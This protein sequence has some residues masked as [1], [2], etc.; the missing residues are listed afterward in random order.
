MLQ[1]AQYTTLEDHEILM[2]TDTMSEMG[3]QHAYQQAL[4]VLA[5]RLRGELVLPGDPD[6]EP[7]RG[8]WNGVAD[9][10]PALIVRC[11]D[12][13]DIIGRCRRSAPGWWN[14][15]DGSQIWHDYRPTAGCGG[16]DS[17]WTTPTSK[18]QRKR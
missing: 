3:G 1:K 12:V 11:A 10:H 18:R 14:R 16:G 15:L 4:Q 9:R 6:Y 7:V 8:V 2:V 17:R 5:M 13:T